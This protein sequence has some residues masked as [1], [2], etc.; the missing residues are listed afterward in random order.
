MLYT[1]RSEY[2]TATLDNESFLATWI[3]LEPLNIWTVQLVGFNLEVGGAGGHWY[4]GREGSVRSGRG[5][6]VGGGGWE[7]GGGGVGPSW[8][9]AADGAT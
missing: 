1:P 3:H 8:D 9:I 2:P 7:R 4:W 5:G 6:I